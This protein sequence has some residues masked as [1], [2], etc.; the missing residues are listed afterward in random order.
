MKVGLI[1][2]HN[3]LN[4][5]AALQTYATQ[6]AIGNL[7]HKCIVIDYVN[8]VRGKKYNMSSLIH[9]KMKHGDI[10]AAVKMAAGSIFVAR[11]KKV[12]E[13]F[14]NNNLVKTKKEYH[15]NE[16]LM[17]LN[18]DFD[19]FL[20]GSDQIWNPEN[21][22]A[23]MA[24]LLDFVCEK[25]KTASYASSFGISEI[26]DELK[27]DYKDNLSRIKFLSAR[28][29]QGIELIRELTGRHAELVLDPVFL[30]S[31]ADWENLSK[32]EKKYNQPFIFEYTN[33]PGQLE[34]ALT[35]LNLDLKKFKIHK[36]SRYISI[37]DLFDKKKIVDYSISPER[38]VANIRDAQLIVTAS[39]HGTA[40]SIIMEKPFISVL[41]GDAGKDSRIESLLEITGLNGRMVSDK[42]EKIELLPEIDFTAAKKKLEVHL[43]NSLAFLKGALSETQ[44]EKRND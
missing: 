27:K 38:F 30:L 4:Y 21:N 9:E 18:D 42:T 17:K 24:F 19:L 31:K 14:Y 44:G 15:S 5:G 25:R 32:V 20:A 37:L 41:T 39:F 2:Y 12:F 40:L 43:N 36:I 26:P 16:E 34:Q 35:A 22:G 28:E 1:T 13:K 10:R 23:D 29:L 11:R 8:S 6:R 33:R 7:G 3:T